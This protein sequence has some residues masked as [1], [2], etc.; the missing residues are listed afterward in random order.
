MFPT[1]LPTGLAS[2]RLVGVRA[3][4]GQCHAESLA[5]FGLTEQELAA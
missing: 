4:S 5:P 1:E 3:T 2:M